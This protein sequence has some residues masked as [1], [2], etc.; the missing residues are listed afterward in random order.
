[1][2]RTVLTEWIATFKF[3]KHNQV[4][5]MELF[6]LLH[7]CSSATRV[8]APDVPFHSERDRKGLFPIETNT[9]ESWKHRKDRIMSAVDREYE[10][11]F[12]VTVVAL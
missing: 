7:L 4:R 11:S 12:V 8:A 2:P 10:V 5:L 9:S 6:D 3:A 1:M